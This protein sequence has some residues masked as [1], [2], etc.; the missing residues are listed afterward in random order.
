MGTPGPCPA[1]LPCPARGRSPVLAPA[2]PLRYQPEGAEQGLAGMGAHDAAPPH[3][4]SHPPLAPMADGPALYIGSNAVLAHSALAPTQATQPVRAL[5]GTR[6][7]QLRSCFQ[8]SN[9]R[10]GRGQQLQGTMI[11]GGEQSWGPAH[12]HPTESGGGHQPGRVLRLVSG[13]RAWLVSGHPQCPWG[14]SGLGS[15][16]VQKAQ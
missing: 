13:L 10:A 1:A 11:Y 9:P 15:S 12:V 4:P 2:H 16:Q 6:A 14:S 8:G 5:A 3:P 7:E